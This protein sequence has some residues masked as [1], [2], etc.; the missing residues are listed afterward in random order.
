MASVQ[1]APSPAAIAEPRLFTPLAQ[2]SCSTASP[3][4]RSTRSGMAQACPPC[5]RWARPLPTAARRQ[6]RPWWSGCVRRCARCGGKARVTRRC[7]QSARWVQGM[8]LCLFACLVVGRLAGVP[9]VQGAWLHESQ[10][11]HLQA[12]DP[13]RG[14]LSCC[15]TRGSCWTPASTCCAPLP[16]ERKLVFGQGL[17]G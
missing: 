7:P 11:L 8:H 3:R 16:S 13:A 2:Q 10:Q 5:C 14:L 15:R 9:D 6:K 1:P 4:G 12:S 17:V